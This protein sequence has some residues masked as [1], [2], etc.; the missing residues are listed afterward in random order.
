MK[1][2]A[3]AMT[4]GA[5]ALLLFGSGFG[6]WYPDWLYGFACMFALILILGVVGVYHAKIQREKSDYYASDWILSMRGDKHGGEI[7]SDFSN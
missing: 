6:G 7:R 2:H 3:I 1:Y 5:V 4:F